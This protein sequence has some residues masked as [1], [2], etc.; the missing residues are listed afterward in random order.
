M[1]KI[2]WI[3]LA[4]SGYYLGTHDAHSGLPVRGWVNLG[5]YIF[6]YEHDLER[7]RAC[8]EIA[9]DPNSYYGTN[10]ILKGVALNSAKS[11]RSLLKATWWEANK[12]AFMKGENVKPPT[13]ENFNPWAKKIRKHDG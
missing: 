7:A 8:W 11:A 9:A 12:D 13:A 1:S 10:I 2:F 4:I 6:H 5:T 3:L